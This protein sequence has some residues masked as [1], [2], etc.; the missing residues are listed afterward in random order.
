MEERVQKIIAAAGVASRRAAEELILDGRVKVNGKVVAE[1]GTKADPEKDHIKVDGKLINPRQ[2]KTYVMLNK[3]VGYVTTMSDPEGR[4]V[5]ATLLQG[6]RTRVYPVGRLDY[7]TEGLLLL[8]NDGDFAHLVTH[9][10]HELPKTYLVK[11]KGVLEDRDV[12]NLERGVFLKDGR[13]APAR[14]RR[15][16]KEESNSWVEITIHEGRKRQVRRMIDHTGK[17]VIKLKRSRIGSLDLG[18]LALGTYRH[19]TAEEVSSLREAAQGREM[20]MPSGTVSVP[21]GPRGAKRQLT[22]IEGPKPKKRYPAAA[23]PRAA[24]AERH[25]EK[26]SAGSRS[27]GERGSR[28]RFDDGRAARPVRRGAHPKGTRPWQDKRSDRAPFSRPEALSARRSARTGEGFKLR[29]GQGRSFGSRSASQGQRGPRP[30]GKRPW[31]DRRTDRTP[32]NR[33]DG[34]SGRGGAH[35]GEGFKPREGQGRSSGSRFASQGQRGARPEGRR[36]WPENRSE[37]TPFSRPEGMPGRTGVRKGEGFKPRKGQRRAFGGRSA[38]PTQHG[39]RS[40]GKRPRQAAG[41][42]FRPG[43][44]GS[45]P[46]PGAQHASG[47]TNGWARPGN[48]RNKKGS[49][50]RRRS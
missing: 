30:E 26:V 2:P 25:P 48:D 46:R 50:P 33:P 36:P 38:D 10:R 9:P 16:R 42:A 39:A 44:T 45:R 49:G 4:P 27:T 24:R 8:T 28:D 18:D 20:M 31:Q 34:P 1:L 17:S 12:E 19:L 22:F 13:T 37:R 3:P 21:S 7:N 47:K 15:L 40:E 23:A 41:P 32:F 35:T 11:V 43:D 6:V 14:V 29:E 5:V